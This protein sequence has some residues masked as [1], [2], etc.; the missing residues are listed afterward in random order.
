MVGTLSITLGSSCLSRVSF[1]DER[2]LYVV[3]WSL[4][5]IHFSDWLDQRCWPTTFYTRAVASS[6]EGD[7]LSNT[8]PF[9]SS[10]PL[11][12]RTTTTT[13]VCFLARTFRPYRQ[14]TDGCR[15]FSFDNTYIVACSRPFS[16]KYYL[17]CLSELVYYRL[18]NLSPFRR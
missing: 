16:S 15:L 2:V 17:Y 9:V 12:V 18:Y 14:T 3:P 1:R 4:E 7:R 10:Q 13:A 5:P 6:K 11:W 8:H